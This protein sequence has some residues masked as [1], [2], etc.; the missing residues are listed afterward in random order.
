MSFGVV[1][2]SGLLVSPVN[3]SSLDHI[4]NWFGFRLKRFILVLP[5]IFLLVLLMVVVGRESFGIVGMLVG[6]SCWWGRYWGRLVVS[7]HAGSTSKLSNVLEQGRLDVMELFG[8]IPSHGN[9]AQVWGTGCGL[10]N[11]RLHRKSMGM[12]WD[13]VFILE[14]IE[15]ILDIGSI[16][17]IGVLGWS[18]D[19]HGTRGSTWD[20]YGIGS[21]P[22]P[23][24]LLFLHWDGTLRRRKS[25]SLRRTSSAGL[26]TWRWWSLVA[27]V[28]E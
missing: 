22:G 27:W 20:G 10:W 14:V 18:W 24:S 15:N 11:G 3:W 19:A 21:R 17:W 12:V 7:H 23:L 5:F 28:I 13:L 26:C 6:W 4:S 9:P 2:L 25:S 1:S 16:L 8:K